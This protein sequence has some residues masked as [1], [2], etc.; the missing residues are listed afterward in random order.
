VLLR[1]DKGIIFTD[2]HNGKA[3][4]KL[5]GEDKFKDVNFHQPTKSVAVSLPRGRNQTSEW[6]EAC[7]GGG[8][9]YSNFVVAGTMTEIALTGLLAVQ[10]GHG[11]QYDGANME[12]VGAPEAAKWIRPP[13][14]HPWV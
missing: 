4:I 10:L 5:T 6:I 2:P 9:T 14:R 1:G 8:A 3:R 7:Q 13:V 11:F 12:V